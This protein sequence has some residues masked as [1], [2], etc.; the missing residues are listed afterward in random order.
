MEVFFLDLKV[1]VQFLGFKE[2]YTPL[3]NLA[4]PFAFLAVNFNRKERKVF[5]KDARNIMTENEISRVVFDAA[6][7]IHKALG[8]GLLESAY[9]ACLCYELTK[10]GLLVEKQIPLPLVYEAVKLETGYR[11]D[12]IIEKKFIIE[13]KAVDALNDIHLAQLLTYLKL[14]NW[15]LGF[16][17]NFNVLLLKNGIRRV[18]DNL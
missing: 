10:T 14:A 6:L 1:E 4:K 7:K 18:V 15:K 3:A 5:A 17:I 2:R 16:L 8:P 9:E 12:I 13:V 11:V